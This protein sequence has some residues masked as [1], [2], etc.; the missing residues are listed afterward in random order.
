MATIVD[1]QIRH[2]CRTAGLVEPFNSDL[3]NPASIDVRLG[4]QIFTETE[5]GWVEIDVSKKEYSMSPG[6]FILGHT[7]ELV[8]IPCNYECIFQ[9]KSSR[10][11]EGY[12]HALAGYI[13]A[14][15]VGQVTLELTNLNRYHYLPLKQGM[16]IG[17][18]RFI[19]LD[20]TPLRPY[21]LTG[22][23]QNN[24]GACVSLG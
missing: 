9:L 8:R 20:S 5:S 18:L 16:K 19:K 4:K 12:E 15:F 3:V 24:T 22:R 11:R 6:E 17:Q 13:D 10:G 21:S 14:G 23:Y 7:L 1:Y 2:L